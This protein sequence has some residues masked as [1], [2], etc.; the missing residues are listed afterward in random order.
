MPSAPRPCTPTPTTRRRSSLHTF[1]PPTCKAVR[2]YVAPVS[3]VGPRR[4]PS[5]HQASL[6][7]RVDPH[8]MPVERRAQ[9]RGSRT[10]NS[11]RTRVNDANVIH[12]GPVTEVVT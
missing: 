3:G 2:D 1:S 5:A 11:R 7:L 12:F 10:P 8:R 6:L 4:R 9:A